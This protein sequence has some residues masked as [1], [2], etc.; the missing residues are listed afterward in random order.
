[1]PDGVYNPPTTHTAYAWAG[2]PLDVW[3]RVEW[4]DAG[5]GSYEWNFGDGASASGSVGDVREISEVHIYAAAGTYDATL[6]VTDDDGLSASAQ[7]RID[8]LPVVDSAAKINLAIER[9]LKRIYLAWSNG[10]TTWDASAALSA[11]A[12]ENRGHRPISA[13][14]DIYKQTVISQL[15]YLF[16][17]LSWQTYMP[18]PGAYDPDANGNGGIATYWGNGD[19]VHGMIMSAIVAAGSYNPGFPKTDLVHNPALNLPVT[20]GPFAGWTYYQVLDDMVEACAWAQADPGTW[21]RG[22]WRYSPNDGQSDNSI[23]QWFGIGLEEAELW[24]IYAPAW[25]KTELKDHWLVNSWYDP[26]G[27][28]GYDWGNSLVWAAHS[29][30]GLCMM[31]YVGIPKDDPWAVAAWNSLGVHW[32]D[33]VGF[34]GYQG[35]GEWETHF[36]STYWGDRANYYAMYAIAKAARIARDNTG[37][38][39]EVTTIG[40]HNWYAEYSDY[41]VP[42]QLGDGSWEGWFYWPETIATP[43]AVLVLE[44]TVGS[45]RPQAALSASPNPVNAGTTVNFDVSGSTHQDPLKLLVSWKLDFDTSD[46]VDWAS[47]DASGTFAAG[48]TA[49]MA[50]GY[51]QQS[52]PADYNVTAIVQVTDN[53]GETAEAVTVVNITTGLVPPVANPGGPY[54]GRVG[55]PVTLDGSASSSSNLGGSIVKYEWDLN[56]NGDYETDAGANPTYDNTWPTPYSGLIGL[57]VTDNFGMTSTASAYTRIIV[58]DLRAVAYPL[59]AHRRVSRTV[60]EYTFKFEIKNVG[61]GDATAVSATLQ[62]KPA[63]VSVVDGSVSFPD[64]VPAGG[65]PVTSLDTFTVRID[66]SVPVQNQDLTWR[67]QYTDEVGTTYTLVHFPLF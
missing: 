34:G 12:L 15:D 32:N 4:G 27:G 42:R 43:F 37:K 57:R 1:M 21:G 19:Y 40:T 52:P 13:D 45:L 49:S 3:G 35:W 25:V 53:F 58:T 28:W 29:G 33:N 22:G 30:A 39:S 10:E 26:L 11:L 62:N 63:Q 50:G 41:L 16:S 56:G 5:G 61:T 64:P 51:P 31:A 66:R 36:G 24:G 65:T 20:T 48:G 67:V 9:G 38:V 14:T 18:Y 17:I 47:P 8:V 2:N 44:Q 23:A 6:T 60:W 54:L 46:G 59:I 55:E 7:V